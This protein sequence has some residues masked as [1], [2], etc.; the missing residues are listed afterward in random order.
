MSLCYAASGGDFQILILY[1]KG[2]AQGLHEID[3]MNIK[4]T[5]KSIGKAIGK[6]THILQLECNKISMSTIDKWCSKINHRN[7]AV[8]YYSGSNPENLAYNGLW[9]LIKLGA[10]DVSL[11]LLA[12]KVRSKNARLSL[13]FSDS[14]NEVFDANAII[15]RFFGAP[16]GKVK[17]KR[18]INKLKR[19][20]L[21]E[22]GHLTICSNKQREQSYGMRLNKR[23]DCMF[24]V[25]T[26]ALLKYIG[27]RGADKPHPILLRDLPEVVHN[28]LLEQSCFTPTKQYS[29]S[30]A[31][32]REE[33]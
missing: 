8:V 19:I 29:F 9:P 18:L 17:S 16:L 27:S 21:L 14:Y 20:W 13:V 2:T 25:F 15:R 5:F 31:D 7:L 22:K 10:Q 23:K 32:I 24:G 28:H 1:E 30:E 33:E 11:D 6:H 26:E 3:A 12:N 4:R